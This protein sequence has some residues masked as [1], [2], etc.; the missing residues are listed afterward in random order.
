MAASNLFKTAYSAF[1]Y[2]LKHL[3]VLLSIIIF[4]LNQAQ[5]TSS[6][7]NKVTCMLSYIAYLTQPIYYSHKISSIAAV[8]EHD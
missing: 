1:I 5:S 2:P 8:T 3:F 6:T 7:Q 4:E